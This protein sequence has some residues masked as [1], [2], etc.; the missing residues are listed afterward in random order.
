MPSSDAAIARWPS[1]PYKGLT[2][3]TREDAMLFAGRDDDIVRCGLLMAE[4]KMRLLLLHGATGCGK[5]SFLR[6]GLI[7]YLESASAGI[8]FARTD[9]PDVGPVLF[10]RS[11]S[12]PLSSLADSIFKFAD[13]VITKP[14]PDGEFTLRL[15]DALPAEVAEDAVE[16]RRLCGN[17]PDI[18]IEVLE[19]LS[20]IVPETLALIIDQGEEVLT[21]DLTPAGEKCRSRFFEFI[22]DFVRAA[23]DMKLL[24]ALRTEYF[25]R[26]ISRA[27]R[28]YRGPGIGE[29]HLDALTNEQVAD[30]ML[31]P[32]STKPVSGLG[33]PHDHYQFAFADGVVD[34]IIS[35]L[36]DAGSKL[37]AVQLVCTSL[38]DTVVKRRQPWTI[39][40]DDLRAI[41]GVEGS[42]GT[43]IDQQL[44]SYCTKIGLSP[45]EADHEVVLW[46]TAMHGLT[47]P[48][49]DGT[50]TTD[51]KPA[52]E[53][54]GELV[55]SKLDFDEAVSHFGSNDLRL[56]RQ[57]DVVHAG[58]GT[59]IPCIGL[60]HD[61]LGL[62][63]QKWKLSA[64]QQPEEIR[65][66]SAEPAGFEE[67]NE[68]RVEDEIALC[69][70]GG[71]Y[72]AMLFHLGALWRLNDLMFLQ[73]LDRISAVSGG[74]IVAAHVAS[75]WKSLTFDARGM[76][77]NFV[78]EIVGPIRELAARTIDDPAFWTSH[79]LFRG[80]ATPLASR[81]RAL[82]GDLTL[83]DWPDRPRVVVSATNLQ[84]G[85]LFRFSK[86]Y[87]SDY[88]LGMIRNPKIPVATVV[89]ASA[90]IAPLLSPMVVKF[91]AEEWSDPGPIDPQF[92]TAV[93]LT[94]GAVYDLYAIETAWKRCRTILISDG[95]GARRKDEPEPPRN[96]IYQIGRTFD[97]V[98]QSIRNLRR[99]QV[100]EAFVNRQR[101][102]AYWSI[103]S[104]IEH[105]PGGG[106]LTDSAL[107]QDFD[108]VP[109]RYGHL[110]DELQRRLINW[111]YAVCDAAM[112][113]HMGAAPMHALPYP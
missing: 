83:Q 55:D 16:F 99:R 47:R 89:A 28:N 9:A 56:L 31:R 109:T 51:L 104:R 22:G 80:D 98:T 93:H 71:G 69:L 86:P 72:R 61:A 24:V 95:D 77:L 54:R 103:T 6:A 75:R 40:V 38:Y 36:G 79:M 87:L 60:G 90:A 74:A 46:K 76:A 70:S 108:S 34:K 105:F 25:G 88:R 10:V 91:R 4:W 107:M 13:R 65:I 66:A 96:P 37:P 15:R 5:S 111:G 3:Y 44:R 63:L 78:G 64:E 19:K 106:I 41:G 94:N 1:L 82:F 11:T 8:A 27:R 32:T 12:D 26:F 57:V 113:S 68:E 7:P 97:L 84:C 45:G 50:V 101:E 14:A 17:D 48:Q 33:A 81:L 30:A 58:T 67:E 18:L 52:K 73:K 49:A 21:V 85:S 23:I 2:Y 100:V 53:M 92:R 29:Y 110:N 102:G 35:E 39:T 59:L 20:R 42:I 43:F 62:V 112:R